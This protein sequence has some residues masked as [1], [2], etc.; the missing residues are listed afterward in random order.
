MAFAEY[1]GQIRTATYGWE[2]REAIASAIEECYSDIGDVQVTIQNILDTVGGDLAEYVRARVDEL[3]PEIMASIG[4]AKAEVLGS[5]T[6]VFDAL[7]NEM[8]IKEGD[9][10]GY[11]L[12]TASVLRTEYANTAS[13]LG[14]AIEQSASHI[15]ASVYAANSQLYSIIEA[16]ATNIRQEVKN[17][18]S[19]FYS[20]V[21]QTDE[22]YRVSLSNSEST[23]YSELTITKDMFQSRIVNLE[24]DVQSQIKQLADMIRAEVSANDSKYYSYIEQTATYVKSVVENVESKLGSMILQTESQIYSELHANDSLLYSYIDR[25]ATYVVS[26][27]ED[28]ENRMGSTILQTASQIY[29]EVHANDSLLYSY[30]DQTATHIHQVVE[31]S[32]NRMGSAILETSSQIR[33]EVHANDSL[34]YS[35]INETATH[36]HQ[37]VENAESR[38]GAAILVTE[39]QIYSEVHAANSALYSY[40]DQTSTQIRQ[41]VA[42]TEEGLHSE[43]L[44]TSSKIG[45]VVS[46][47]NNIK[48]A[49]IVAAINESGESE[50]RIN[51]EKVYIGDQKSTTVIA[52][53]TTMSEVEAKIASFDFVRADN[54]EA[55]V[56][57]FGYLKTTNLSGEI[58]KIASLSVKGLTGISIQSTGNIIANGDVNCVNVHASGGIQVGNRPLTAC[59]DSVTASPSSADGTVTLTF[60]RF[61]GSA[62]ATVTFNTAAAGWAKAVAKVQLPS[63]GEGESFGITVPETAYDTEQSYT[64]T[65]S[66]G[67]PSASGGYASVRFSGLGVG[68]VAR[69]SISDWYTSGRAQGRKDVVVTQTWS[70]H[71]L[72]VTKSIPGETPTVTSYAMGISFDGIGTTAGYGNFNLLVNGASQ[73]TSFSVNCASIYNAG[74]S[75]GQT[76]GWNTAVG[77]ISSPGSGTS[78]SFSVTVPNSEYNTSRSLTF[79]IAKGTPAASGYA[80]VSLSGTVVGRIDISDWYTTGRTDGWNTAVGKVSSPGGGTGTTFSVSVPNTTYNTSRSLTFSIAKG[81][82]AAS[83][84]ASVSLSGTVVGRI[85]ISDWYTTGRTDGW[86]TAVG[87]LSRPEAGT[88]TSFSVTVPSSGYNTAEQWGFALTRDAPSASG[89]NVYAY[90]AGVVVGQ[91][92]IGNWYTTGRTDGWNTAVGK[93]SSPG[94]GTGTTF[95]VSV[96]NTT[97]NTSRSLTFSITKGTP[98]AS[99]YAAVSLSGTVVG[100]IDIS[101]WYTTGKAD[102]ASSVSLDYSWSNRILSIKKNGT[103]YYTFDFGVDW[104]YAD[105]NAHDYGYFYLYCNSGRVYPNAHIQCTGIYNYGWVDG[106][107]AAV[108][109]VSVSP[110][111]SRIYYPSRTTTAGTANSSSYAVSSRVDISSTSSTRV[112]F[113]AR[114]IV[115]NSIVASK[116][117][118]ATYSGGKISITAL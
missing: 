87:K 14:S 73:G 89:G 111:Y 79:S 84:Y 56:A 22:Y 70:G 7:K 105:S 96:P 16:T 102:G 117:Y 53:K 64:F 66:K 69:I 24:E 50:A 61:N 45:L 54:L 110:T 10:R 95:S 65:M 36:I 78:T 47:D 97:Y 90:C 112:A 85:D 100:R 42:D 88:S 80:S 74:V 20:L 118:V 15:M 106:Y 34:I 46:D 25:T 31:D 26:V 39:S 72:N 116:Q 108:G 104:G 67:T 63:A 13:K 12:F 5:V 52:G 109:K 38:L 82:P 62:N 35:Y 83:G 11:V 101:D 27:V 91:V 44:Q 94:G 37:V 4:N 3:K 6:G 60:G 41:V 1:I 30:I 92:G 68:T 99:G 114:A 77:K 32:E 75:K 18:I 49:S 29:S 17:T 98:A 59:F 28:T 2:V 81:T 33:S 71:T 93:V 40:V 86:N 21:E 113:W 8:E 115:G 57:T 9:L 43:I 107:N 48:V 103:T 23:I 51:A 76:D 55:K 19:G 58:G